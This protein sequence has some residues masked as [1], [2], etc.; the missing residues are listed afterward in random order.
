MSLEAYSFHVRCFFSKLGRILVLLCRSV[1][2]HVGPDVLYRL[3]FR[4]ALL[5]QIIFL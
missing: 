4:I 3:R 5:V 1:T 2:I